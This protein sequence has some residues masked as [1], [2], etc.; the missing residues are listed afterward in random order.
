[1]T[2]E[3]L[4]SVAGITAAVAAVLAV[5]VAFGLDLSEAQ[6]AA[7]LGAVAVLAP[8]VV[9]LA[10]RGKVTPTADPRNDDGVPLTEQP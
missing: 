6:T 9:A 4:V 10:V 7:I 1:M 2:R 3:P 5:L 8:L